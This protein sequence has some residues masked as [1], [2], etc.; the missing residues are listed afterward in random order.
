MNK[1]KIVCDHPWSSV[2]VKANGDVTLCPQN[3]TIIGNINKEEL[4]DMWN[5]KMQLKLDNILRSQNTLSQAVK[6]NVHS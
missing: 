2:W 1:K 3:R 6:L 4:K 5:S